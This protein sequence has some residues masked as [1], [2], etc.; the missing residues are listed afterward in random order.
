[1]L[2]VTRM[3]HVAPGWSIAGA[4]FIASV[5]G[6]ACF[7]DVQIV[8]RRCP[9][10]DA[11]CQCDADQGCNGTLVCTPENVCRSPRCQDGIEGCACLPEGQCEGGLECID[12]SCLP[13][14]ETE[15]TTGG[16]DGPIPSPTTT[17]PATST[18]TSDDT[19]AGPG[20]DDGMTIT[21]TGPQT[22][23]ATDDPMTTSQSDTEPGT[24]GG[25][26]CG[27]GWVEDPGWYDCGF[28]LPA[29]APGNQPPRECPADVSMLNGMPCDAGAEPITYQ[30]C[31]S[32][33]T[34]AFCVGD[35][36]AVVVGECENTAGAC[37]QTP[38]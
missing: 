36:G 11:T 35:P 34:L 26:G 17:P 14:M 12:D 6:S 30:G 21:T 1:M 19:G 10:G 31:C 18:T 28:E 15:T 24:S 33:T 8:S 32:G 20:S 4:F 2:L 7:Q 29:M 23:G 16:D 37:Q 25:D 38:I 5:L 27:C 13:P 22:S 9:V 3:S